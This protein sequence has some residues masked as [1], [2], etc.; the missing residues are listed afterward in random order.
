MKENGREIHLSND[1]FT[2]LNKEIQLKHKDTKTRDSIYICK[3]MHKNIY[4]LK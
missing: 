2:T 1:K 4:N 3:Q